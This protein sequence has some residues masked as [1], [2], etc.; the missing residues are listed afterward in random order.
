MSYK[1]HL[2]GDPKPHTTR[3]YWRVYRKVSIPQRG[4]PSIKTNIVLTESIERVT[5]I[6]KNMREV[7]ARQGTWFVLLHGHPTMNCMN[8]DIFLPPL[9][10]HDGSLVSHSPPLHTRCTSL[11]S[12]QQRLSS[13][14]KLDV[15][16]CLAN[17]ITIHSDSN[18]SV[19]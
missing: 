3:V 17:T 10:P 2:R 12:A 13:A 1:A 16:H 7:S 4:T 18:S 14:L 11:T 8:I 19:F 5:R 6:S 9:S 15:D